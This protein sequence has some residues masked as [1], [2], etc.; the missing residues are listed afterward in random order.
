M[1]RAS[2]SCSSRVVRIIG[3]AL[4]KDRPDNAVRH[5]RQEAIEQMLALNRIGL[6]AA[7]AGPFR[8]DACEGDQRSGLVDCKPFRRRVT[9]RSDIVE[10]LVCLTS[11]C[12]QLLIT[13]LGRESRGIRIFRNVRPAAGHIIAKR[14]SISGHD[15]SSRRRDQA[16]ERIMRAQRVWK[17]VRPVSKNAEIE[18]FYFELASFNE[19]IQELEKQHPEASKIEALRARALV[20]ARQI[21]EIRCSSANDLTD[22]LA[23]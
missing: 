14:G 13:D 9:S 12:R 18:R 23:K 1:A 10:P 15:L 17:P 7:N 2:T 20:L 4:A 3:I 6:R 5:G 8:T 16:G 11:C 21:D 22:L 19:R